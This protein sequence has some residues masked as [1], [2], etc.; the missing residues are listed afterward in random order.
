MIIGH[1]P[2][3]KAEWLGQKWKRY[4]TNC[5]LL[6]DLSAR[7]CLFVYGFSFHSSHLYGDVN[8]TGEGLQILFQTRRLRLLNNARSFAN[9]THLNTKYC[10]YLVSSRDPWNSHRL[11]IVWQ[12]SCNDSFFRSNT[13]RNVNQ[14]RTNSIRWPI[15]RTNC[16]NRRNKLIIR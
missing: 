16:I 1:I 11:P 10:I 4:T 12:K 3:S 13:I 8:I 15:F 14:A 2:Y 5:W 9:N 6:T 7:Y